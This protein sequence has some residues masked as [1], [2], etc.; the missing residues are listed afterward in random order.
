MATLTTNFSDD[1][2]R[3]GVSSVFRL[4]VAMFRK[5]KPNRSYLTLDPK[6]RRNAFWSCILSIAP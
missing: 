4:T 3:S 1:T 5:I 6:L 2:T